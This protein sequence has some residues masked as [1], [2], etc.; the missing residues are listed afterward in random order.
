MPDETV[1][2]KYTGEYPVSIISDNIGTVEPGGT[3]VVPA[4]RAASYAARSDMVIGVVPK[5]QSTATTEPAGTS[6]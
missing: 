6:A 4:H 3:F 5:P 1:T 2:V